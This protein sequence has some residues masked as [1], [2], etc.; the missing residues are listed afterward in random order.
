[1]RGMRAWALGLVAVSSLCLPPARAATIERE[2]L[3][4]GVANCQA[5][6]A[7]YEPS[8]RKKPMGI[9]NI[10]TKPVFLTCDF[11][12]GPNWPGYGS[13]EGFRR[14]DV[15]F[16]NVSG[17]DAVVKCSLIT[18][19][20]EV[21]TTWAKTTTAK[22]LPY[23]DAGVIDWFADT[24]NGGTLFNSPALSCIL[25]PN[26]ELSYILVRYEEDIGQ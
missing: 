14:I 9:L 18:G 3:S 7:Q 19:I 1:M 2:F 13:T 5:A 15:A 22:G 11:D 10:G 8:L 24:D 12:M 6:L 16:L 26:V 21:P 20:L 17:T 23:N 25:P 4:H